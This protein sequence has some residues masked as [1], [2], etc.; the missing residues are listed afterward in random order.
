MYAPPRFTNTDDEPLLFHTL[1]FRVGSVALAFQALAPL[2]VGFVREEV[3]EH[4]E[5]DESGELLSV[6][7]D[8]LKRGN[9]KMK[10]WENT[11]LGSIKIS[12]GSLVAEVNSAERARRL[13]QEIEGRLGLAG[14]HERTVS[15]PLDGLREQP[16]PP[17]TEAALAQ[18]AKFVALILEQ[19]N[20]IIKQTMMQ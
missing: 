9:R 8:W 13:R 6:E 16:T 15:H 5:R 4:A 10:T 11:I 14:T 7:F 2:A 18:I 19:G 12:G 3:L 1:T 17:K 20:K